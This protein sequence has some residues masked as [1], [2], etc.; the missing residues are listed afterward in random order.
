[1]SYFQFAEEGGV[2]S[3]YFYLNF[4]SPLL[5]KK[6]TTKRIFLLNV[7]TRQVRLI[8]DQLIR[9]RRYLLG[10]ITTM[11]KFLPVL[12]RVFNIID[13]YTNLLCK[14]FV[15]G[16]IPSGFTQVRVS[17]TPTSVLILKSSEYKLLGENERILRVK[18][19]C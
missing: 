11:I 8:L 18:Q 9:T 6:S 5:S 1:M 15:V 7:K 16:R 13:H 3:S 4:N 10:Q 2:Q 14:F 17:T 12:K 19:T